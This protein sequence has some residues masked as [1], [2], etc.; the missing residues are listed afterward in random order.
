MITL[1]TA[2]GIASWGEATRCHQLIWVIFQQLGSVKQS[3]DWP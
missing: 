2:S 1:E 3:L